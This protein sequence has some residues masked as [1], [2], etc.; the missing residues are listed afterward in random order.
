MKTRRLFFIGLVVGSVADFLG[1]PVLS[2]AGAER[3]LSLGQGLRTRRGVVAGDIAYGS[4]KRAFEN[5]RGLV[6]RVG[7]GKVLQ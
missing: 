6:I 4:R 5:W 1:L 7:A 3:C 2:A